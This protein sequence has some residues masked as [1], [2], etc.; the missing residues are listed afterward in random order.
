MT[1]R[2][3]MTRALLF[4]VAGLALASCTQT[5][6][7]PAGSGA[8]PAVAT[9]PA[10][11]PPQGG[12]CAGEIARTRAVLDNDIATG[13]VGKSVGAQFAADLEQA[14]KA[15]AAGKEADAMRLVQATK[16]RF[17]YR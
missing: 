2:M 8:G 6:A 4:S 1:M 5:S 14:Q 13:N 11:P 10:A 17:G 9:A 7:P 3:R 12:G 15:C 16:S